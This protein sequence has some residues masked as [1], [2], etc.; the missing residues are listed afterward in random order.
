MSRKAKGP[1][2]TPK[3]GKSPAFKNMG[4]TSPLYKAKGVTGLSAEERA[5]KRKKVL[6]DIK[7]FGKGLEGSLKDVKHALVDDATKEDMIGKGYETKAT[8]KDKYGTTSYDPDF[9]D[10][11]GY[12]KE[13]E[14]ET[15]PSVVTD[16]VG[17]GP[18][19]E[20]KINTST[21]GNK[22]NNYNIKA[23]F[24]I[25]QAFK[26]VTAGGGEVGD[27]F[28]IGDKQF[29]YGFADEAYETKMKKKKKK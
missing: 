7:Q 28:K 1:G 2:Y 17:E 5:A 16:E 22:A 23:D 29:R 14:T 21:P 19:I 6:E 24:S 12:G 20:E 18:T 10:K 9:T 4:S 3:S 15:E 27:L 26:A 8:R 25:S 13:V 11:L